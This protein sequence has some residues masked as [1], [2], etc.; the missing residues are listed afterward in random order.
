MEH[1]NRQEH[2]VLPQRMTCGRLGERR[3]HE[4]AACVRAIEQTLA[5]RD[6]A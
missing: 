3:L 4:K 2:L 5:A 6:D 1:E